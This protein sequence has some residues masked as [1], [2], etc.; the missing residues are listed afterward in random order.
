MGARGCQARAHCAR[1]RPTCSDRSPPSDHR[2]RARDRVVPIELSP[3]RPAPPPGLGPIETPSTSSGAPRGDA[4]GGVQHEC[5]TRSRGNSAK[6]RECTATKTGVGALVCVHPCTVLCAP[7]ALAASR[8]PRCIA[9]GMASCPGS[10]AYRHRAARFRR[11]TP[12]ATAGRRARFLRRRPLIA[13]SSCRFG[14]TVSCA[15]GRA[16]RSATRVKCS[17]PRI[18]PA[19]PPTCSRSSAGGRSQ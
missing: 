5:R 1:P 10:A 12:R 3:G 7:G 6:G 8:A 17:S 2:G 16:A 9:V 15:V 18:R 14:C 11:S 13:I 19:W 4:S